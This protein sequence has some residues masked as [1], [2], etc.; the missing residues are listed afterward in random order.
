MGFPAAAAGAGKV[1]VS[2]ARPRAPISVLEANGKKHLGKAEIA[3][4]EVTEI[5]ADPPKQ[6]RSPDALPEDLR[7]DFLSIGKQLSALGI[8]CKLDYDTLVRYLVARKF[9]QRAADEI[10]AAMEQDDLKAA[11]KWTNLQDKYFKQCRG[12]ANDLGMT[13]GARCRLVVPQKE[14]PEENPLEA[15]L[16]RRQA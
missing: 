15:L 6:I 4:R 9:W 16:R 1:G 14:E 11:E 8:F 7:K 10:A 3:S 13:I 2:M 5:N 12:C